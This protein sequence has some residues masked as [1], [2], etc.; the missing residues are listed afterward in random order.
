MVVKPKRKPFWASIAAPAILLLLW[1]AMAILVNPTGDFPLN[2]DW[3]FGRAVRTLVDEGKYSPTG[4][5]S[6]PLLTHVLWGSLFCLPF[7]FS[8]TTLR[9][10]TLVMGALGVLVTYGILRE[11]R[12]DTRIPF[13]GALV[14]AVNPLY[15]SLS[16]T[17]M[18]DVT[19]GGFSLL[20]LFYL[21]RG[22]ER[23][24][25]F[26]LAAGHLLACCAAL[27]RQLGIAIPLAFGAAYLVKNGLSIKNLLR[28][29]LP[30]L[31]IIAVLGLYQR[32]L[33]ST[34]GL[35]AL[36]HQGN[37]A[38]LYSLRH[39]GEAVQ[40]LVERTGISS[41]YLGL[42]LLPFLIPFAVRLW[43]ASGRRGKAGLLLGG[44]AFAPATWMMLAAFSDGLMPLSGNILY[45]LG[46]GPLVL[47]DT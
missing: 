11:I 2:D 35:P 10:S 26:E 21:V 4:W 15:F 23:G 45:D 24:R 3:S 19:F 16:H 22:L 30:F 32:W 1:I 41:I 7:G 46:L 33:A 38:L 31:L 43:R 44:L 14:V 17:F 29:V 47:R 27:N 39:S 13:L 8:F 20:S 12:G 25:P 42:F 40:A 34:V 18:T 28:A 36:Y 9:V 5:T 37:D 6:M